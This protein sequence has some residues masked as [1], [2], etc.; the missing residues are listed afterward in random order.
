M[1]Q[2]VSK[3]EVIRRIQPTRIAAARELLRILGDENFGTANA[4]SIDDDEVDG[5]FEDKEEKMLPYQL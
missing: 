5:S 1:C 3:D 2:K 4:E